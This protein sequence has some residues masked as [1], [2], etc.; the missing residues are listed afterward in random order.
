MKVLISGVR[1]FV[2]TC[3]AHGL[4]DN[5]PDLQLVGLD[6]WNNSRSNAVP[7]WFSSTLAASTRRKSWRTCQ[8]SSIRTPSDSTR[9]IAAAC[10]PVRD[11]SA[12]PTDKNVRLI[13]PRVSGVNLFFARCQRGGTTGLGLGGLV[14]Y[15]TARQVVPWSHCNGRLSA[16]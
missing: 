3:I 14:E 7:D 15:F 12:A 10:S 11:N 9:Q 1:E 13:Y 16:E 8:L 5:K 6:N 4:I 2:G